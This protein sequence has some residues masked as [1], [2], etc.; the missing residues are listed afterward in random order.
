MF[1]HHCRWRRYGPDPPQGLSIKKNKGNPQGFAQCD[2]AG[3]V[4][5][6]V[7]AGQGGDTQ[8]GKPVAV[9]GL[10]EKTVHLGHLGVAI[11]AHAH[12]Q[13]TGTQYQNLRGQVNHSV[14]DIDARTFGDWI[15]GRKDVFAVVRAG[16]RHQGFRRQMVPDK[17][18]RVVESNG[19]S[20]QKGHADVFDG[21]GVF[22]GETQFAGQGVYGRQAVEVRGRGD[23]GDGVDRLCRPTGQGVGAADVSGQKADGVDAQLVQDD[24]CGVDAFVLQ[25][26]CDHPYDDARGHDEKVAV[27]SG[28]MPG[29]RRCEAFEPFGRQSLREQVE[30][31]GE[32]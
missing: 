18:V 21:V 29:N 32:V 6:D 22:D 12:G 19:T 2:E 26:R 11:A 4:S 5:L 27:V 15:S 10:R 8:K 14:V 7:H 24:H 17:A 20:L 23:D 13:G 31:G 30:S 16:V 1:F 9:Q 25:K 28:K 3:L